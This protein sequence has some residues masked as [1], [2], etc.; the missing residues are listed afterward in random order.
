MKIEFRKYCPVLKN[1]DPQNPVAVEVNPQAVASEVFCNHGGMPGVEKAGDGLIE[2]EGAWQAICRGCEE[3]P[4]G[5]E[6][7]I[8]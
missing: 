3:L 4:E 6:K 5:F 2:T 7:K 8:V 1:S